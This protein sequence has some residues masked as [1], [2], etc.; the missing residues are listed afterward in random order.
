MS[1]GRW[2]ITVIAPRNSHVEFH[3]RLL[4]FPKASQVS[5][6]VQSPNIIQRPGVLHGDPLPGCS[7]RFSRFLPG[8]GSIS[9]LIPPSCSGVGQEGVFMQWEAKKFRTEAFLSSWHFIP[10]S[11]KALARSGRAWGGALRSSQDEH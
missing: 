8:R 1:A 3:D 9:E 7:T 6:S 2:L 5:W 11:R 10:Q 4:V